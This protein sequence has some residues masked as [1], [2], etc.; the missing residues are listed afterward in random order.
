MIPKI[1]LFFDDVNNLSFRELFFALEYEFNLHGFDVVLA[2]NK[3][4][5]N[6][7]RLWIGA[8]N[9]LVDNMP[10]HYIAY[11]LDPLHRKDLYF[12]YI[13]KLFVDAVCVWDYKY[14]NLEVLHN[15]GIEN[16]RLVPTAYSDYYCSQIYGND[17]SIDILFYGT[18]TPRRNRIV[19]SLKN[20]GLKICWINKKL[21]RFLLANELREFISKSKI[22]VS[23][24]HNE[25]SILKNSD[26]GRL[27]F[28]LAN[29]A[30]MVAESQ[31]DLDTEKLFGPYV[32]FCNRNELFD[33]C[34]HY[35]NHTEERIDR[36]NKTYDYISKNFRLDNYIPFDEIRDICLDIQ[37][38]S[39]QTHLIL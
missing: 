17:E 4:A 5:I 15:W 28:L 27:I 34:S 37:N 2:K 31:G 3:N 1:G 9:H 16:V 35:L 10:K 7:D 29:K 39:S 6:N 21:R 11:N 33:V 13:R 23:I 19:R 32:S 14:L 30:F 24:A 36:I 20:K 12:E 26:T 18:E 22:V 25:P 38:R 8:W